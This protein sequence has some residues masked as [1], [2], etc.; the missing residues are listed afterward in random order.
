MNLGNVFSIPCHA[1]EPLTTLERETMAAIQSKH[2]E[3]IEQDSYAILI[4]RQLCAS[5]MMCRHFWRD[6]SFSGQGCLDAPEWMPAGS[7]GYWGHNLN[8]GML[9]VQREGAS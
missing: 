1:S 9:V 2:R 5:M 3:L 4:D 8:A 7:C 6:E